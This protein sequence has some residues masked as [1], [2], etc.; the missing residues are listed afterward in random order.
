MKDRIDFRVPGYVLLSFPGGRAFQGVGL[1]L[2]DCWDRWFES[3]WGHEC[4][5]LVFVMCCVVSGLCEGL[6]TSSK[7]SCWVCVRACVR[8]CVELCVIWKSQ[9]RG[10]LISILALAPQKKVLFWNTDKNGKF[11]IQL[12]RLFSS[13]A[14]FLLHKSLSSLRAFFDEQL[15]V[16]LLLAD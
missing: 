12:L 14:H 3:R 15:E 5:C 10:A 4:F 16:S 9:K 8:V 1:W 11:C 6:V 2:P 13:C 7:E